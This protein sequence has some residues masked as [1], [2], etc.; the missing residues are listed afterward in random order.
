M[1]LE[2][3]RRLLDRAEASLRDAAEDL[4]RFPLEPARAC[5]ALE[6]AQHAVTALRNE[7]QPADRDLAES[8]HRMGREAA[9]I[10]RLLDG[11]AVLSFQAAQSG[12]LVFQG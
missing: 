5:A 8:L 6:R 3:T 7:R 11:A 9:R 2:E 4:V 12:H 1:N 10:S